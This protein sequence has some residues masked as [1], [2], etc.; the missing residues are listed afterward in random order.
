MRFAIFALSKVIFKNSILRL[1][2]VCNCCIRRNAD[3]LQVARLV[4]FRRL[5]KVIENFSRN[6][7]FNADHVCQVDSFNCM[8]IHTHDVMHAGSFGPK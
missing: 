8:Y 4:A 6:L 7:A 1:I 3:C 5:Q 2:T